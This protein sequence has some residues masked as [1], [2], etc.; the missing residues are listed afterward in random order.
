[1]AKVIYAQQYARMVYD[2]ELHDRLLT[3]V[4][5]ADPQVPDMVLQNTLAQERAL[6]L[7]ASADAYF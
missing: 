5:A 1:M 3:E 2:R 6:A 4:L 7:L